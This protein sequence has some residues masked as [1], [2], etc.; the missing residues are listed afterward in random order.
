MN[1]KDWTC[2]CKNWDKGINFQYIHI[3][4]FFLIFI[5]L[6]QTT[7]YYSPPEKSGVFIFCRWIL[8]FLYAFWDW[9]TR[10][11]GFSLL[12]QWLIDLL[13]NIWVLFGNIRLRTAKPLHLQT[14][15]LL[16]MWGDHRAV[17]H[18]TCQHDCLGLLALLMMV[19]IPLSAGR[20]SLQLVSF[21]PRDEVM[22]GGG[23]GGAEKDERREGEVVPVCILGGKWKHICHMLALLIFLRK[24]N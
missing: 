23:G 19:M 7:F 13:R 11:V 18:Y 17:T 9:V 4:N 3:Y 5:F 6:L 14:A 12:L 16:W 22:R 2:V 1:V 8:G 10:F 21:L 15:A 20:P 24:G